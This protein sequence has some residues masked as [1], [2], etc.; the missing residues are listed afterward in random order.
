MKKLISLLLVTLLV[1]SLFSI[2]VSAESVS[3]VSDEAAYAKYFPEGVPDYLND[4]QIQQVLDGQYLSV[5]VNNE[6]ITY[7]PENN[8]AF[9][10]GQ[11]RAGQTV[12]DEDLTVNHTWWPEYGKLTYSISGNSYTA[13][14]R[15]F[16]GNQDQGTSSQTGRSWCHIVLANGSSTQN[17]S[18]TVIAPLI[19]SKYIDT[20]CSITGNSDVSYLEYA[21]R[22]LR[23]D[24]NRSIKVK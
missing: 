8:P 22:N 6:I 17:Q 9:A 24:W 15:Y 7:N 10:I 14:T 16:I 23:T 13:T 18:E 2:G 21:Y 11:T 1:V 20:S 19:G 4:E 12:W 5:V 3:S